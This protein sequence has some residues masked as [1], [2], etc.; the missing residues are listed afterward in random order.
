MDFAIPA[1]LLEVGNVHVKVKKAHSNSSYFMGKG[2]LQR[3][4]HGQ[5]GVSALFSSF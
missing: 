4:T 1:Q 2:W 3:H 5:S